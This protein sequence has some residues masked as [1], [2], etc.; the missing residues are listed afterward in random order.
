M[1]KPNNL[2][3][4][5]RES[6]TLKFVIVAFLVLILL[7]PASMIK[8]I[9]RERE[10]TRNSVIFEISSK[11]ANDQT[12]VGPIV[13]IPYIEHQNH[14]GE[15][16]PVKKFA[17][18]LPNELTIIGDLNPEIRYRGIYEVIVYNSVINFS[19]FFDNPDFS[20]WKIN[21]E[22]ILFD[23]TFISFG[24]SDMRGINKPILINFDN[25]QYEVNSGIP[26]DDIL[27]TGISS[28]INLSENDK[29]HFDVTIDFNGSEV[30]NFVPLGKS[31]NV[32]LKSNWKTPSFDGAFLP[33]KREVGTNGFEAEWLILELNRNYPQKWLGK[34]YNINN[35]KFG[36]KLIFPVDLYQKAYRAAKYAIMFLALTFLV[37]FFS[38]VINK[39][40]IHPIQYL[41][42]GIALCVFYTLL[43][44]LAEQVG[45]TYAY[46]I[47]SLS[48][49]ILITL[50]AASILKNKKM[51]AFIASALI[52]LYLFLFTILQLQDYSL[53]MGSIGLFIVV[54]IT[55]Y[56]SRKIDWYGT[57]GKISSNNQD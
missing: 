54:A 9:I 14:Q 47:A 28:N 57:L 34:V 45:F 29:H 16:V 46:I 23:E 52:A 1:Y 27:T 51:T 35:S 37:F 24:I 50:Y 33:D 39:F 12:I 7:I 43:I 17:H 55:M 41:L 8:S 21:S 31:T 22:S 3:N 19:G 36:V 2:R 32:K 20:N 40:K 25:N 49:I 56:L 48:T 42:V 38:E 11:W 4:W 6:I 18:F 15:M 10:E 30:L 44:S 13:T 5:I 26:S 53:L